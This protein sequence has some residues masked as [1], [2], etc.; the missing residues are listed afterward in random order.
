MDDR[1]FESLSENSSPPLLPP[2]SPQDLDFF[3]LNSSISPGFLSHSWRPPCR[4]NSEQIC[5]LLPVRKQA[6]HHTSW[7]KLNRINRLHFYFWKLIKTTW[8]ILTTMQP[9]KWISAANTVT[10]PHSFNPHVDPVNQRS[11]SSTLRRKWFTSVHMTTERSPQ[12]YNNKFP[13]FFSPFTRLE[14]LSFLSNWAQLCICTCESVFIRFLLSKSIE[15][16]SESP[17]LFCRW[18]DDSSGG[19]ETYIMITKGLRYTP[20]IV[21]TVHMVQSLVLLL[22][23]ALNL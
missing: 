22:F 4:C 21:L 11:Y 15:W 8:G 9:F 5:L 12:S 20:P 18:A 10:S 2:L 7:S 1:A 19:S 14:S 23:F 17:Y 16:R 3:H 13:T 6:Q